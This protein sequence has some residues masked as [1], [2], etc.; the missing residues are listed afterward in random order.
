MPDKPPENPYAFPKATT[1]GSS[2][3]TM[4]DYFAGQVLPTIADHSTYFENLEGE[5]Y[6]EKVARVCYQLADAMLKQRDQFNG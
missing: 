1:Y 6:G 4:R 2:G 5:G 3:M